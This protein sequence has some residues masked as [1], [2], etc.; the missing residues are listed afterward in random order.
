MEATGVGAEEAAAVE[1]RRRRRGR[2]RAARGEGAG[3]GRWERPPSSWR[4]RAPAG[5]VEPASPRRRRGIPAARSSLL[6]CTQKKIQL[7][8]YSISIV[9]QQQQQ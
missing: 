9:V 1:A 5:A 2:G 8:Y 7:F 4:D 6:G 3:E